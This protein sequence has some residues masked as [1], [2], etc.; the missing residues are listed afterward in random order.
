MSFQRTSHT[1]IAIVMGLAL[2]AC[3]EDDSVPDA[4]G[5]R[6]AS[7]VDTPEWDTDEDVDGSNHSEIDAFDSGPGLDGSE[8][9]VVD[10]DDS[11]PA[12]RMGEYL[13]NNGCPCDTNL[14]QCCWGSSHMECTVPPDQLFG[15][16]GEVYD[17][18]WNCD[19]LPD[20]EDFEGVPPP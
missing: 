1:A 16:W 13:R 5:A 18:N 10:S 9:G 14:L 7:V 20:C 11:G 15:E 2:G 17:A 4:D 3:T 19:E 6:D 8:V 12:C